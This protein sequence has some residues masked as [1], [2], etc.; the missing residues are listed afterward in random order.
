MKGKTI[1]LNRDSYELLLK[2]KLKGETSSDAIVR[3][4]SKEK[5]KN[6]SDYL[7]LYLKTRRKDYTD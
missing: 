5:S 2:N 1:K 6:V 7:R 3:L 4:F